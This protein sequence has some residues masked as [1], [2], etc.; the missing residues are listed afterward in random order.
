MLENITDVAVCQLWVNAS[1]VVNIMATVAVLEHL[2]ITLVR[3]Q[4]KIQVDCYVLP[5]STDIS[6]R[7]TIRPALKTYISPIGE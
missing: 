2:E 6:L 1:D 3:R 7:P 5:L 4:N